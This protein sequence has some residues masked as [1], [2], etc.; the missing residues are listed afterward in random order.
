MS[1]L[2]EDDSY[3]TENR[4]QKTVWGWALCVCVCVCV[5]CVG[6]G[7]TCTSVSLSSV[8]E[9]AHLKIAA[10]RNSGAW[11]S[12]VFKQET[13]NMHFC[14]GNK[15]YSTAEEHLLACQL[16]AHA[17]CLR[18][19]CLSAFQAFLISPR[20]QWPCQDRT[21]NMIRSIMQYD[22]NKNL[23]SQAKW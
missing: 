12:A 9:L 23:S 6:G 5:W 21:K 19:F 10:F 15:G 13:R 3:M 1:Q 11:D 17:H 22:I 18:G 14:L 8:A 2:K 7:T 20:C 16:Q 4:K